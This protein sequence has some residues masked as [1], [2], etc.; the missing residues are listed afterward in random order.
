MAVLLPLQ[1][2]CSGDG[3]T[4]ALRAPLRARLGARPERVCLAFALHP[5]VSS[6]LKRS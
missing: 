2:A 6:C 4:Q 5:G 1:F 3:L